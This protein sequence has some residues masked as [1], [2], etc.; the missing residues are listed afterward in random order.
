MTMIQENLYYVP[1]VS[2]GNLGVGMRKIYW[3]LLG[4]G[5]AWIAILAIKYFFCS[6]INDEIENTLFT[7][8]HRIFSDFYLLIN[9]LN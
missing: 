1:V 6:V 7:I 2:N 4:H 5:K 9:L 3:D 8:L